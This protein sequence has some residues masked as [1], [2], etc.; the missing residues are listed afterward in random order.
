MWKDTEVFALVLLVAGGVFL[1][2]TIVGYTVRGGIG[3]SG[4]YRRRLSRPSWRFL[5]VFCLGVAGTLAWQSYGGATKQM[6]AN[7][8]HWLG[9]TKQPSSPVAD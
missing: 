7:S 3:D 6:I 8:I 2:G 5:I 4:S 9:W 1:L